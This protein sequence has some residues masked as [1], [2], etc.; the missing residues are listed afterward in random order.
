V[1]L[2]RY[3][4]D[5]PPLGGVRTKEVRPYF[6][7]AFFFGA[8]AFFAAFLAAFFLATVRPPVMMI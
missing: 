1:A 7:L 5:S 3:G 8:A 6:F 2:S 4:P